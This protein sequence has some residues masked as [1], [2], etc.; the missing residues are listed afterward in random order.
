[1]NG[2]PIM[3]RFLTIAVCSRLAPLPLL[4]LQAQTP[5]TLQA[6]GSLLERQAT[7]AQRVV[8][9]LAKGDADASPA[10]FNKKMREAVSVDPLFVDAHV[11]SGMATWIGTPVAP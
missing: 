3:I 2:N 8:A 6:P 10:L 4:P 5:I 7:D 9:E 1:M 11:I